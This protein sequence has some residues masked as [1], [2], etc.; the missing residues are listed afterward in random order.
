MQDPG[1]QSL[2]SAL[3]GTQV[4]LIDSSVPDEILAA[5]KRIEE[6]AKQVFG[7]FSNLPL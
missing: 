6:E 4:R 7:R 5:V 1:N 2:R 3:K